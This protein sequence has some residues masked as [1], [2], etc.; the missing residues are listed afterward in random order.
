MIQTCD[1]LPGEDTTHRLLDICMALNKRIDDL[2][3]D[4]TRERLRSQRTATSPNE[5]ES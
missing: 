2:E 4:A 5:I 1:L 3:A